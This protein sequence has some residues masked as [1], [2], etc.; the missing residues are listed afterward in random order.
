MKEYQSIV[1][2][3]SVASEFG[4]T[5]NFEFK[6]ICPDC[7]SD[8]IRSAGTR[9]RQGGRV[10]A[11]RCAN[12]D[13]PQHATWEGQRN[14]GRQFTATTSDV[15]QKLVNREVEQ[16]IYEMY[17]DGVEGTTAATQHGV[18]DALISLLRKSVDFAI[19]RG[20][21]RDALVAELTNDHATAIDEFFL[22]IG[23]KTVF[24]ILVRGYQSKKVLGVNVSFSRKEADVKKAFDE[25]QSN[26]SEAISTITCDAWGGTLAMGRNLG[27]PVTLVIH[28]HKKPYDKVVVKR[29]EYEGEGDARER[30][31]TD[32]GVK[33]D[34]FATRGKRE[35]NIRQV[36]ELTSKPPPR[37]IGRPKGSK[38]RPKS[39]RKKNQ[40]RSRSGGPRASSPSS[41]GAPSVTSALILAGEP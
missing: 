20:I 8:N 27:R 13:C 41:G 36:R 34:I 28:K 35:Y 30:V 4:G 9:R 11:Y 26:S 21:A 14:G 24:V 31:T 23:E 29:I 37:P 22:T 16:I 17:V 39:E 38:N 2:T 33:S 32:I 3:L 15:V 5:C 18:S 12:K 25:A 6:L 7:L 19:E 1:V 10:D 40:R